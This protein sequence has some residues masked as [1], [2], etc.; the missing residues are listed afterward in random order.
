MKKSD[1]LWTDVW[2]KEAYGPMRADYREEIYGTDGEPQA[3]VCMASFSQGMGPGFKEG[4]RILDYGCGAGRYANFL[5]RRLKSFEY[6]GVEPRTAGPSGGEASIGKAR[7]WFGVDSRVRFGFIGSDVEKEALGR[8]DVVLLLSI[9]THTTIE[10]TEEVMRKMLPVVERGGMVV[11][12]VIFG[13]E[14]ELGNGDMAYGSKNFYGVVRLTV[15]QLDEL[16]RR[17]GM[18]ILQVE[19]FDAGPGAFHSICR[20][21]KG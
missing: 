8:V 19:G 20:V 1:G 3:S 10:E 2:S 15:A 5:S 11:F 14:Y 12:S 6:W 21:W 17:L 13:R 4:M 16:G 7:A 18:G 9:F